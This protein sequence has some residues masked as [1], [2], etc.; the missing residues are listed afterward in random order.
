[1]LVGN[2]TNTGRTIPFKGAFVTVP[3]MGFVTLE[4][5]QAEF[6][7]LKLNRMFKMLVDTN[8]LTVGEK[9]RREQLPVEP[10]GP[11]VPKELEDFPKN[12]KISVKRPKKTKETMEV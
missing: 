11:R 3:P 9:P 2:K 8:V 1:M 5:S 6:E 7:K 10:D 4:G 12:S